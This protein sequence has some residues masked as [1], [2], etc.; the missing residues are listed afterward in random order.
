VNPDWRVFFIFTFVKACLILQQG[1]RLKTARIGTGYAGAGIVPGIL[2]LCSK[3]GYIHVVGF[4][5]GKHLARE[6]Q[7]EFLIKSIQGKFQILISEVPEV[8]FKVPFIYSDSVSFAV[9]ADFSVYLNFNDVCV[10]IQD[11]RQVNF[12][13]IYTPFTV[14]VRILEPSPLTSAFRTVSF[15]PL[16]TPAVYSSLSPAKLRIQFNPAQLQA[17]KPGSGSCRGHINGQ[18]GVFYFFGHY[19]FIRHYP[20]ILSHCLVLMC[21]VMRRNVSKILEQG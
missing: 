9:L 17:G 6:F 14:T 2:F 15:T 19:F 4:S 21:Y 1:T 3:T 12:S 7:L 10:G 13:G 18:V 16:G 20:R 8:I 11:Y 5:A